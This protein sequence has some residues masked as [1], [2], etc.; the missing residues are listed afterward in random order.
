MN[1]DILISIITPYYKTILQTLELAR[2]LEPQLNEKIEWIIIDDGC[3]ELSLDQ[4]NAKVIHLKENSGGASFPRNV[5]LDIAKGK[6]IL[7]IDSD[8]M[9]TNNYIEVIM[10]KL[11]EDFD[12]CYISWKSDFAEIII[13]D[14]PPKWNCCVWNC[15]YKK[16]LIGNERFDPKLI[17]AEDYDFNKRVRKGKYTSITETIYIYKNNPNSL[18]KRGV[19]NGS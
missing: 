19:T 17:I 9:I 1:D 11:N 13:Q 2:V 14:V 6:F 3:D 15:I 7:F 18:T 5:G 10:N 8:D 12:Y 16:E 4:I